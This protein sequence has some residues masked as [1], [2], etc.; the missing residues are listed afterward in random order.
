MRVWMATPAHP[1]NGISHARIA[2]RL[3]RENLLER[4]VVRR[5]PTSIYYIYIVY[6]GATRNRV[7][8]W[9]RSTEM[10]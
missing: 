10:M 4:A 1:S 8:G 6:A 5:G 2:E 3:T 7:R 9:S